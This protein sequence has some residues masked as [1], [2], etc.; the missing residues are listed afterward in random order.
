MRE[1]KDTQRASV[2]IGYDRKVHKTFR[3]PEA[4]ERFDNERRVLKYLEERDCDF[5]PRL[6]E[7][8]AE[9]LYIV[10]TNC[11]A[12]VEDSI[13]QARTDQ[14]YNELEKEYGVRHGDPASRNIT[15]NARLGRF[16]IIDFEY[17]VILESGEGFLQPEDRENNE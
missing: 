11:G 7:Y 13:S 6:V 8:D 2:R 15:Y 1:I 12:R 4:K 14:L 9:T 10:T 16:C 3:G 5:V 17:A